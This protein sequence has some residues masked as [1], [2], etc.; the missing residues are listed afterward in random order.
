MVNELLEIINF[1][2]KLLIVSKKMLD[3]YNFFMRINKVN[4][5]HTY[6]SILKSCNIIQH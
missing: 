4:F 5:T 1:M 3:D 6:V 2:M